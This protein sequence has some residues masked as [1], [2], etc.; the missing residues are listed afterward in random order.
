MGS[1]CGLSYKRTFDRGNLGL[2]AKQ[3]PRSELPLIGG[4]PGGGRKE[5][6]AP[7]FFLI[8]GLS[9]PRFLIRNK[10]FGRPEKREE[11]N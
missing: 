10:S 7:R 9:L 8:P 11:R 5:I 3:S 6:P 1:L 2:A 4:N